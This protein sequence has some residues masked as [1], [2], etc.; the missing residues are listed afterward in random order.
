[1]FRHYIH[2]PFVILGLIDLVVMGFAFGLAVFF[3]FFGEVGFFFEHL[4]FVFPSIIAFALFNL[5]VMIALGVHQSR[6]EEG[7]SGMM[8]RTIMAMI[9]AIPVHGFAYFIADDWLWY[10]G[11]FGLLTSAT[12]LAVFCPGWQRGF[13]TP[14]IGSWCRPPCQAATG[15]SHHPIQPQRLHA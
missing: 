4:Y 5:V 13:Q 3:R 12:V 2:L 9:L 8:L 10:L 14:G 15:R 11:S 1:L 7:M 6:V